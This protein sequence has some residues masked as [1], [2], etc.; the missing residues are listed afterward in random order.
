M[1]GLRKTGSLLVIALM[2]CVLT[3]CAGTGS[4][5]ANLWKT[6]AESQEQRLARAQALE[7]GKHY[8]EARQIYA[9]LCQQHPRSAQYVHRLGVTCTNLGDYQEANQAFTRAK[10]L[11]PNNPELLADMGYAAY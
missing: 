6:P 10:K 9:E 8:A 4:R 1:A 3:G 11:D 7:Q 5:L 2:P